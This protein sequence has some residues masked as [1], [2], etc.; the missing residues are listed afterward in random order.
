MHLKSL[1]QS[2]QPVQMYKIFM[3][4]VVVKN[5]HTHKHSTCN[6]ATGLGADRL[7]SH[8]LIFGY[9]LYF[10]P[11]SIRNGS[12]G[13][14]S[15]GKD[16]HASCDLLH[17][18]DVYRRFHWYHNR[19][20]HPPRKRIQ[21]RVW[22]TAE[23]RASQSSWCLLR[24]DQVACVE[25]QSCL[26]ILTL[27]AQHPLLTTVWFLFSETCFHQTWSKLA[28]SR[29]VLQ[30]THIKITV[31]YI[32]ELSK[33]VILWQTALKPCSVLIPMNNRSNNMSE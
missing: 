26:Q 6:F 8:I 23:D 31:L 2:I 28:H 14:Q 22:K 19:P 32:H 21:R 24:S 1:A 9:W 18:H 16:G 15:F 17:D 33:L 5:R 10:H 30:S 11:V 13:Q 29:W 25:E 20:H 27:T 3:E 7:S 12:F 4:Y